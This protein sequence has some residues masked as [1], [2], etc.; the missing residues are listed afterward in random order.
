METPNTISYM[1]LGYAV[2]SVVFFGYIAS[3]YF[4]YRSLRRDL[5]VLKELENAQGEV[6]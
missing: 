1:Y 6:S 2:F 4:R 3:Y 5:E